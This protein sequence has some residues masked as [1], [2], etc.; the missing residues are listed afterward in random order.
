[1]TD[2]TASAVSPKIPKMGHYEAEAIAR[3]RQYTPGALLAAPLERIESL[4]ASIVS[5]DVGT[6]D[7]RT[8]TVVPICPDCQGSG[9]VSTMDARGD[10]E[11]WQCNRCETRGWLA[12][13]TDTP[14]KK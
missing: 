9:Y 8:Q 7:K 2:G 5:G 14:E 6:Y 4:V 1:M 3:A 12:S 11:E 13:P 10:E